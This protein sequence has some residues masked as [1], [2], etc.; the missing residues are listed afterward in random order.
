MSAKPI[1]TTTR[2]YVAIWKA[3]TCDG[4]HSFLVWQRHYKEAALDDQARVNLEA[5]YQQ[6]MAGFSRSA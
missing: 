4:Q 6:F 3:M 5:Y 1:A 2:A